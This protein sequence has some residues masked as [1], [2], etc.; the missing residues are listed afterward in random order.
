[1]RNLLLFFALWFGV[2]GVGHTQGLP[3]LRQLRVDTSQVLSLSGMPTIPLR[4]GNLNFREGNYMGAMAEYNE[5][6]SMIK[7]PNSFYTQYL[8]II[9]NNRGCL[10]LILSDAWGAEI[11]FQ[12]AIAY[13]SSYVNAYYNRSILASTK[14]DLKAAISIL[15]TLHD[16][17]PDSAFVVTKRAEFKKEIKDWQGAISDYSILIKSDPNNSIYYFNRGAA[18][19]LSGDLPGAC[20]DWSKSG[21]LGNALAYIAIKQECK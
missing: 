8:P 7:T 21:E 3:D 6:I 12:K 13:D 14:S 10:K 17:I 5:A 2:S 9:L 15:D 11:D 4:R 20:R 1:M 16:M 19:H 18:K